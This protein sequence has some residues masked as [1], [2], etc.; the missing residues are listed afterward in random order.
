M[1][2]P[3]PKACATCKRILDHL[4]APDGTTS[5]H[6]TFQDDQTADHDP[7]PVEPDSIDTAFRCDFCNTDESAYILPVRDFPLPGLLGMTQMMSD[8]DW[9]ACIGCALLID[10]NQW[11][12]LTRRVVE[13][14]ERQHG[15]M[16]EVVRAAHARMYKAVRAN[17]TGS[18]RPFDKAK[19]HPHRDG[20]SRGGTG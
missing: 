16:K 6:H 1:P 20:S 4:E 13:Y 7:V 5:W 2:E 17:I 12:A 14:Y 15:P 11:T 3:T 8:G 18:L 10:T 19:A 9:S